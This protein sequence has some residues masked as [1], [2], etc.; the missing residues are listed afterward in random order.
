MSAPHPAPVS[1][2]FQALPTHR[3]QPRASLCPWPFLSS[4]FSPGCSMGYF[5]CIYYGDFLNPFLL[6]QLYWW[7][8]LYKFRVY[9][10]FCFSVYPAASL[11]PKVYFAPLAIR[12][13]SFINVLPAAP[14]PRYSHPCNHYSVLYSFVFILFFFLWPHV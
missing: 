3:A 8:P 4:P 10:F 2:H 13:I 12:L 11:P 1:G 6:L 5:N 9:N 14:S 7:I